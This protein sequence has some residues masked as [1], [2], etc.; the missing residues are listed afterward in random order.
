[1]NFGPLNNTGGERRLNV[2]VSRARYEM[3]VY[4]TLKAS[5]IDLKRSNAKGVEGLKGFLEFAETGTLPAVSGNVNKM[6]NNVMVDQI[7][8]ALA[9]KGYVTDSFVGRSNFKVDIAVATSEEPEKYILGILCDGR[10]YYET[11]T[12]RDRE[13]VQPGVLRMLN[14][15]VMR[16]YSIDWYENRERALEQI[17][18]ELE[19]VDNDQEEAE[20]KEETATYIFDAEKIRDAGISEQL[21]RNKAM[22]PYKECTTKFAAVDKDSFNPYQERF[23][24]IIKKILKDEQPATEGYLCKRMAKAIGFG[25]AGAN[26]QRAVAYAVSKLYQDPLS[27]GGVYSYWLDEESAKD[28]KCYRSPSPRSITEIPAIE[29]ANAIKEVIEEEFSLPKDKIPTIAA[30]KLGFSSAGAKI[31]EVINKTIDLLEKKSMIVV[32][33]GSVTVVD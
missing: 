21:A 27:I 11:K 13:I 8:D 18:Q 28:Y 25:H 20:P 14:W 23:S 3:I 5:Q 31:C 12:T 2:A 7:G 10:N 15:R 29:I 1:M 32:N 16:V 22:R 24:L 30:R 26:V 4:S 17:L 9:R 33:N 19:S 6:D